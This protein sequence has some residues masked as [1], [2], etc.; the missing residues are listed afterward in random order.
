MRLSKT[1]N[2]IG[3]ANLTASVTRIQNHWLG[4]LI[5]FGLAV[6]LLIFDDY[7][8]AWDDYLQA[9]YGEKVLDY[10]LSG[11]SDKSYA[12]HYNLK[13]F[14]PCVELLSAS[15]HRALGLEPRTF[16]H[17]ITAL[18]ALI[19]LPAISGLGNLLGSRKTAF[20]SVIALVFLPRFFGHAFINSKDISFA[21]LAA[22]SVFGICRLFYEDGLKWRTVTGCAAA[23]GLA[24]S[25]RA[26]GFILFVFLGAAGGF[27]LLRRR[28]WKIK[29]PDYR[30]WINAFF[31][32]LTL[33]VLAWLIMV[34][35]WPYAH[36]NPVLNPVKAFRIFQTYPF[37][38]QTL[39]QGRVYDSAR[40]PFHYLIWYLVITTPIAYL[41]LAAAGLFAGTFRQCKNWRA[42][43]ALVFF[44]IQFWFFFPVLYFIIFRP[45]IYDGIRHML[46]L[47]PALALFTGLGAAYVYD[48]LHGKVGTVPAALAATVLLLLHLPALVRL[49]PYQMTYF[50]A[51]AGNHETIH[52]RYETDYWLTSYKEAAEW[53]NRRQAKLGRPLRVLAAANG[54]SINCLR[55]F[56]DPDIITGYTAR[57]TEEYALPE[58]FDYY[59]ST[60]RFGWNRNFPQTPIIHT[61]GRMG[62]IYA[63]IKGRP[64][65]SPSSRSCQYFFPSLAVMPQKQRGSLVPTSCQHQVFNSPVRQSRYIT[66]PSGPLHGK[67]QPRTCR[68]RSGLI[69]GE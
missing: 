67:C 42:P 1:P 16:R 52:Q 21:C 49:H 20:F 69:R 18:F 26:G 4:I 31:K 15:V 30:E 37:P 33:F 57:E 38:Q 3:A 27:Q 12:E 47:L 66:A 51:L 44:T 58:D 8:L 10:Y 45:N 68:D 23:I 13:Y 53:L 54:N 35:L 25:V 28:P 36:E 62:T 63:V 19:A 17:L 5:F 48:W 55:Y 11:F 24:L 9:F 60:L 61:I 56:L 59:V 2:S 29:N 40:L 22:W 43:F 7:G 64:V 14:G 32:F 41:F 50:N 65:S 39:F 46:F 34:S 6:I